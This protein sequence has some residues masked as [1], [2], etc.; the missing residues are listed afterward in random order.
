MQ[1]E[2]HSFQGQAK[3]WGEDVIISSIQAQQWLQDLEKHSCKYSFYSLKL[4]NELKS[5]RLIYYEL[6]NHQRLLLQAVK[7]TLEVAVT[8]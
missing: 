2:A 7:A 3:L 1:D 4:Y 6:H 8:L 5:K